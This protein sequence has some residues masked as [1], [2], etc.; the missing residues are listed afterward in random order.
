MGLP[1]TDGLWQ[2]V[3]MGNKDAR[4]REVKKPKKKV[5]KLPPP[6]RDSGQE[7]VKKITPSYIAPKTDA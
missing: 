1:L 3:A 5:P 4:N 7:M 6:R 2:S